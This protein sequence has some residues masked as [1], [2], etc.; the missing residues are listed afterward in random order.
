MRTKS[1]Y[2]DNKSEADI[3]AVAIGQPDGAAVA[4]DVEHHGEP[5]P[6]PIVEIE[7]EVSQELHAHEQKVAE[8]D[9]AALALKNQIAALRQSE[10]LQRQQ[11]QYL[12]QPQRPPTRDEK[13]ASWHAQGMTDA[14][15]KFLHDNPMMVDADQLLAYSANEAK[16]QGHERGTEAFLP[17]VKDIFDTHLAHLQAQA[18]AEQ[19]ANPDM[20]PTPKFFQPPPPKPA[21]QPAPHYSAPVSRTVPGGGPRPE[22]EQNPSR[23]HLSADEKIIAK[24]SGISEVEYAKQRIRMLGMKARGEIV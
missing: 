21:P 15:V 2:R 22:F 11:A 3:P 17:A 9:E 8:A 20:Q 4:V 19:Q 13:L 1:Q 12:A 7:R 10:E 16:Q 5:K 24:N 18:Q 6:E 14:A 23:V